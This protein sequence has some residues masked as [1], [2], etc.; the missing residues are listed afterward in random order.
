MGLETAPEQP[1]THEAV[2]EGIVKIVQFLEENE[3]PHTL[4]EI[5]TAAT[6]HTD[7]SVAKSC[8]LEFVKDGLV[9]LSEKQRKMILAGDRSAIW[10]ATN[11]YLKTFGYEPVEPTS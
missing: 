4:G 7:D 10:A 8:I 3:G 11:R 1:N 2:V 6:G 5:Y 9:D